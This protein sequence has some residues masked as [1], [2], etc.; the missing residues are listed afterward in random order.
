[1]IKQVLS[2]L[3]EEGLSTKKQI[4]DKLGIKE[5]TLDDIIQILLKRGFLREGQCDEGT[6]MNVAHCSSCIEKE[7]CISKSHQSSEVFVTEKGRRY[8]AK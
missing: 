3:I 4:A 1:M 8:A 7:S 5:E 2:L 6:Q